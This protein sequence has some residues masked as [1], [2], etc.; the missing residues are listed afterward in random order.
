M[1]EIAA[2][3]LSASK[4]AVAAAHDVIT[5]NDDEYEDLAYDIYLPEGRPR[6]AVMFFHGG[7]W[8]QGS[9]EM[10]AFPLR[11]F[12]PAGIC[13]VAVTYGLA[14]RYSLE[15][16]IGNVEKAAA[17]F[18]SMAPSLG[19]GTDRI[20][21]AGHSAG[22][23]LAAALAKSPRRAFAPIGNVLISGLF[24]LRP[25]RRLQRTRCL[26]LNETEAAR[27]SISGRQLAEAGRCVLAV[28]SVEPSG[29]QRQT[30]DLYRGLVEAGG[31]PFCLKMTGENHFSI[32]RALGDPASKLVE[33]TCRL[34]K[35]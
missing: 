21:L 7:F 9:K 6:G 24:D 27:L 17:S 31:S 1:A 3:W 34:F 35:N 33:E 32:A 4:Q 15:G 19:I 12:A 13:Y 26:A 29:F 2:E 11:G 16:L 23:F 14:P 20:A 18:A 5:I 28:G 8:V 30:D 25:I 10:V 22:A